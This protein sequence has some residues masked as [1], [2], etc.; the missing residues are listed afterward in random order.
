MTEANYD[1]WMQL[2]YIVGIA[3]EI[4]LV[5]VFVYLRIGRAKSNWPFTEREDHEA[6]P[7]YESYEEYRADLTAYAEG[8]LTL[9]ELLRRCAGGVPKKDTDEPGDAKLF[10]VKIERSTNTGFDHLYWPTT[11]LVI[12]NSSPYKVRVRISTEHPELECT[13][14]HDWGEHQRIPGQSCHACGCKYFCSVEDA[15]KQ[16]MDPLA[17]GVEQGFKEGLSEQHEYHH[18][19]A[20]DYQLGQ[21]VRR[22][23]VGAA[24]GELEQL[25][26]HEGGGYWKSRWR[27]G[28]PTG[29][30]THERD[31]EHAYPRKGEHWRITGCGKPHHMATNADFV[32]QGDWEPHEIEYDRINVC[33]C[34]EP[35]GFGRG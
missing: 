10:E 32:A 1:N 17:Y 15:V 11:T 9:D 2:Y 27:L 30:M 4:V 35:V 20:S 6:F 13:C 16:V 8:N 31:F 34:L 5:G 25:L 12:R 23:A 33:H 29:E 24:N 14:G 18:G 21:W 19:I 3:A 22:T 28:G 7:R 26:S